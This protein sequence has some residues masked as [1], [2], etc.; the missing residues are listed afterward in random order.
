MKIRFPSFGQDVPDHLRP[1]FVHLYMDIFWFG[2]LNGSAMSFI[3]VYIARIGGT[4]AHIGLLGALPAIATL[5]FVLPAGTWLQKGDIDRKVVISSVIYRIFY[6]LWIPLPMLFIKNV[7]IELILIITFIMSI[8]GTILQVGFNQ[9][10]AESVPVEW[11]G[12]VAGIRN[13]VFALMAIGIS[14]LC[15]MILTSVSFPFNYQIVFGI[16]FIGAMM[17]SLHLWLLTKKQHALAKDSKSGARLEGEKKGLLVNL[18]SKLFARFD[19]PEFRNNQH[20][21]MVMLLLFT[22]HTAQY[23]SIPVMPVFWVKNLHLTDSIISIGN[24]VFFFTVFLGSTMLSKLTSK[25]GNKNIVGVGAMLMALYPGIM[26]FST[27]AITFYVAS[28]AGGFAWAL[29]GGI[30]V[31]YLLE[32]IPEATRAPFLAIYN[33]VF[34][35]AVLIGSLAGPMIGNLVGLPITLLICGILRVATGAAIY[36]KG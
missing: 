36:W 34:F 31:N 19:W 6:L 16:G 28:L 1:G 15:G 10:F 30:L 18:K 21:Y 9:L 17:S 20:F 25:F 4:E 12:Y 33:M 23:L 14:L 22:F 32:K 5:M 8:P 3:T 2:V 13:A 24:G 27:N 26:A 7:Q 35:A 29:A 11:R